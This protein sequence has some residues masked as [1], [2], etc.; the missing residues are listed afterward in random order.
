M[1]TRCLG[2]GASVRRRG[3]V[4]HALRSQNPNC[5]NHDQI[6]DDL[7]DSDFEDL[8][9]GVNSQHSEN[10]PT[11]N[12][13]TYHPPPLVPDTLHEVPDNPASPAD[14]PLTIEIDVGRDFFG[15][16]GILL[17]EVFQSSEP[18][19]YKTDNDWEEGDSDSESDGSDT[20]DEQEDDDAFDEDAAVAQAEFGLEPDRVM[21]REEQAGDSLYNTPME[22]VASSG[23]T[24]LRLRGG[25]EEGLKLQP[26][27]VRYQKDAEDHRRTSQPGAAYHQEH[28][29]DSTNLY[30]PFSSKL[31]WE[32][33]RWAKLRGPSSTAFTELMAIDGVADRL[34]LS[35]RTS[36]QLNAIIDKHLVGRPSFTRQEVVV[37]GEVCEFF[38]RDVIECVKALFGDP[39]F[40]PYLV[41]SPEKQYTNEQQDCRVY[42]DMHTGRWW[43]ATQ[44][45][46][47][48]EKPG[49]TVVPISLS[50]DKTLLTLFRNKQAYP[51]YLTIGNI[52]KE[53]RR[54]V[55]AHAYILL[56]YLPITKLETVTNKAS[57][58]RQLNNLYH[59]CM[60][61]V[62]KPLEK[63]GVTGLKMVTGHG[64][65]Y[66]G[67]PIVATFNGDYP[68][69]TLATGVFQG[70]CPTCGIP[71]D[72]LGEC[73]VEHPLRDLDRVLDIIDSFD[74]DPAGFLKTCQDARIKPLASPFWKNLPYVHIYQ[75]IAPDI[76]HQLHQGIFKHLV[77]WVTSVYGPV[78]IDARC[79]R[80]PPNHNIRLFMNGISSLSRITGQEHDQ[81]SRILL[82]LI[83]DIRIPGGYSS[84][85]V[86]RAV[87]GLLDFLY[88]AQYP[89]HTDETLAITQEALKMF[90]DNKS[91]FIDL[92]IR[93]HFNIPKL[94]F[95]THW[96]E[97]IKLFGTA[98]NTDTQYTE[99]LHIDIAKDAYA[100]TNHKD[101]FNQMTLWLERREKIFK[102][103][104]YIQWRLDGGKLPQVRRWIPPG[105]ELDQFRELS[106]HPS[107]RKIRIET[108]VNDY[109]AV[110][111]KMALA[112][113]VSRLN[114]PDQTTAQLE[115]SVWDVR[116]PL[117][118]F[119]VWH[120]IKYRRQDTYTGDISTVDSIHCRPETTDKH[121][122]P[123]PARFDTALI[124][125]GSG[126]DTGLDGYRVGRVRVVFSLPERVH[127][128]MFSPGTSIPSHL[129]YI[130]WFSPFEDEPDPN[131]GLYRIKSTRS[132]EGHLASIVP[133]AN[134]RRSVHLFPHFGPVA[135][136]EWKS[137][138]VLDLCNVFHLNPFSHKTQYRIVT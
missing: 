70:E 26:F 66:R 134:I 121:G 84:T 59:A 98:D 4:N 60:S 17:D 20:T 30:A 129:A 79:R 13:S 90:H 16:H 123:V 132:R 138:N 44:E 38:Y 125:L 7:S 52:P 94:H 1:L 11:P 105:L 93:E 53:I 46:I 112:R 41:F 8:P 82:G 68:E 21:P 31:E 108:L 103:E 86:V 99:R 5:R 73:G 33:A 118:K 97:K 9:S 95:A 50:T 75:A 104:Q 48:R 78:E 42:H 83:I 55:S 71:H 130:E 51:L 80:L 32:I 101:E 6:I 40:A 92:G 43:W 67:H 15:E 87:R 117:Q 2:C 76:L 136:P 56:A 49:A 64:L 62:L 89:I 102:H 61:F 19:A 28:I 119:H 18:S 22:D 37:G 100:A 122:R 12:S 120:R 96:V 131:H 77:A 54:K 35:F 85:R 24:P 81:I 137:S 57:R 25:A 69:Q 39:D 114:N 127:R 106:K 27:V 14:I 58:R 107:A 116:I 72:Q 109:G 45:A 124:N 36:A 29:R 10:P 115:R 113:F 88:L 74:E 34:G 110:H 135:P 91:V 111:F 65:A 63:A 23:N 133:V 3:L 128:L 126:R 47:E